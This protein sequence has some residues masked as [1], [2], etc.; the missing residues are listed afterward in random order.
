MYKERCSRYETGWKTLKYFKYGSMA[1]YQ[2]IIATIMAVAE[3]TLLIILSNVIMAQWN[4]RYMLYEPYEELLKSDG[5]IVLYNETVAKMNGINTTTEQLL[6]RVKGDVSFIYAYGIS[7]ELEKD[8]SL[9]IYFIN[10][11][12][13]KKYSLPLDEGEYKLSENT[14]ISY[15]VMSPNVLGYKMGDKI[16]L[17]SENETYNIK[18]TGVLS[19][20]T[21]SPNYGEYS[22]SSENV[23]NVKR[24]YYGYSLSN[25]PDP[26]IIMSQGGNERLIESLNAHICPEIFIIYNS[27]TDDEVKTANAE[28]FDNYLDI[29]DVYKGT[30]D[31]LYNAIIKTVPLVIFGMLIIII[32][33]IGT[34]AINTRCQ[35]R[36]YGVYFLC[37]ARWKD[38][39]RISITSN[40]IIMIFSI[41]LSITA[42]LTGLLS[43]VKEKYGLVFGLNN[44]MVTVGIVVLLS[45]ISALIPLFM[46]RKISPVEVIRNEGE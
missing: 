37:G 17:K 42:Y 23:Y 8:L 45:G 11:E 35:I 6:E 30:H 4:N 43:G 16:S 33:L 9:R 22:T 10:D 13:F 29:S 38:S 19:N 39:I 41:I 15:G 18:I 12:V 26:F 25:K 24:L 34:V 40:G 44:I 5:Q 27:T 3:I 14:D 31:Y 32:G 2:R 28:M 7:V 36:N 20:P 1:L 21:Y 46:L